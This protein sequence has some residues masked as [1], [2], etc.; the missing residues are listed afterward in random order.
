MVSLCNINLYVI[1]EKSRYHQ[2]CP[3]RSIHMARVQGE[4]C[5]LTVDKHAHWLMAMTTVVWT[6]SHAHRLYDQ[7]PYQVCNHSDESMKH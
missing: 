2:P 6:D 4:R 5:T 1:S 7:T 3:H